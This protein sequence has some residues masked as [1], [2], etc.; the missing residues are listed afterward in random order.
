MICRL[1]NLRNPSRCALLLA[2]LLVLSV[3]ALAQ[4]N[5]PASI[6]GTE[7]NRP[8][9]LTTD[10]DVLYSPLQ[11][12]PLSPG[13]LLTIHI[14]G[15]LDYSPTVRISADGMAL[16]PLIGQIHLGGLTVTQ[17][18]DLIAHTLVQDGMYRAPQVSIQLSEG[19]GG[20][21]TVIGEV[22]GVYPLLG[23][24]RLL[25]VLAQAGGLPSTASHVIT[26]DRPGLADPIVVDLGNDPLHS[27]LADVPIHPGDTIVVARLGSIYVLGGF[28]TLGVVPLNAYNNLTL[29]QL[30]SL[31]GGLSGSAKYS[32]LHIIRSVG[33]HRTVYTVDIK[34]II[35]GK[36]PDPYLQPNDIIYMPNSIAKLVFSTAALGTVL[37]LTSLII[38]LSYLH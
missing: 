34:K 1:L 36:A 3:P 32:R 8:I 6:G 26:I 17:A 20:I 21:V 14:F 12:Q 22:H 7:I 13:D 2:A 31:S 25:D 18:Q 29:T 15:Q 33:N 23:P 24:R 30:T 5:G 19:S 11:D 28:K 16:L 37:G 9:S 38:T 27:R 35:N 4:F 10:Q